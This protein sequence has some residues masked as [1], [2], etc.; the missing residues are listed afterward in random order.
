MTH[1]K[2]HHLYSEKTNQW[3]FI[4]FLNY[5][6]ARYVS[7]DVV[8]QGG[9]HNI[10]LGRVSYDTRKIE[11]YKHGIPEDEVSC[12]NPEDL[13]QSAC[14]LMTEIAWVV[15]LSDEAWVQEVFESCKNPQELLNNIHLREISRKVSDFLGRDFIDV[16]N[17]LQHD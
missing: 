13:F 16:I 9:T 5:K 6:I 3:Y 15:G 17:W 1:N 8:I 10:V 14:T 12:P 11:K 7:Y 4:A 2:K